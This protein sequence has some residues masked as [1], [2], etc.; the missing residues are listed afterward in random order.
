[1]KRLTALA[2]AAFILSGQNIWADRVER[3]L[4]KNWKFTRQDQSEFSAKDIDDSKWQNVSIPHDWAIYGPFSWD[5]DRQN[6]A[7]TQDGQKEAMEHA[8]R[9]GGL[10]FVGTGWYRTEIDVTE[11]VLRIFRNLHAGIPAQASIAMCICVSPMPL[12]SR[13]GVLLLQLL[14]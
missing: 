6:V 2:L 12:I 14:K 3:T 9:T 11:F 1:M 4:E 8:G 10:P 5:N 7:I 13:Y